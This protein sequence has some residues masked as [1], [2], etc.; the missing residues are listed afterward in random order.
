MNPRITKTHATILASITLLFMLLAFFASHQGSPSDLQ[1]RNPLATTLASLTGPFT[2]AIARNGQAC[3][4]EA[5]LKLLPVCGTGL[6]IAIA[7]QFIPL[8]LRRHQTSI[9]Y[10]AWTLGWLIWF[11]GVPL[12]LLHAFA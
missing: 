2:G 1:N 11:L 9:R 12:S 7:F 8:K 3:C 6:A 10:T 4:T 5:S